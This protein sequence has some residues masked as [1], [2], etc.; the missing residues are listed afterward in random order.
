[1]WSLKISCLTILVVKSPGTPSLEKG[2]DGLAECY[3]I[4]FLD[5]C[6]AILSAKKGT[7][8]F[9]AKRSADTGL[10]FSFCGYCMNWRLI[11][12]ILILAFAG[13][14]MP[15]DRLVTILGQTMGTTF[16]VKIV[17]GE[18]VLDV[19]M[20]DR[21][22]NARLVEVNRQMST[23]QDD[24]EISQFNRLRKTD[25]VGVSSDF[26]YV[27]SVAREIGMWSDGAFDITVGPLVNLWGFGPEA[28]PERVPPADSIAAR[29]AWIGYEKIDVDL[30]KSTVKKA[31]PEVYCD[32]SAVAK[33]F[34]VDR[35]ASYLDS[36]RLGHYFIEIGGEVRTKGQNHLGHFWRVGIASPFGRGGVSQALSMQNQS[37]ATSGDYHNYFEKDGVR[38]SHTIDP[39]TGRP[40]SHRLASV[41]VVHKSC[42][43]AD[44]LA[45]AINVM[46]PLKGLA[47]AEERNLAVLLVARNGDR[48]EEK[49]TAEFEAMLGR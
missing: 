20:L 42:T 44:G 30:S 13:C 5:V 36:L 21:E 18:E 24:S 1:M 23:Y 43:Y 27:V 17:R 11:F 39:R 12:A 40:I 9:D 6:L 33:G 7:I 22:I 8:D 19:A 37:M 46:G 4:A 3:W 45:T 49:M 35:V 29:M 16:Q 47:F 14:E 28:V 10:R 48:F 2:D 41:S 38:Y 26:A 31:V 34:G 32:L 15:G 25:W